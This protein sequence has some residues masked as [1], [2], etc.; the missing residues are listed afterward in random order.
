MFGYIRPMKSELLVREYE[1][2]KAVY[3]QL[4]RVLGDS[5]GIVSRFT[6]SYDAAFYAMIAIGLKGSA[7]PAC[8]KRC[9]M[10]PAK[11]CQYIASTG[12]EYEKAA[13]LSVMM[14]Y[15]KAK[16]NVAD[17]RFAKSLLSRL[18]LPYL[19]RKY[20]KAQRN[21]PGMAQIITEMAEQQKRAE[22]LSPVSLDACCEPTAQM[23]SSL[24]EELGGD[25]RAHQI[26]LKQFGYFL[27]RWVYLMDAAD[28]LKDD[29]HS[30]S[31]N[32]LVDKLSLQE[33][34]GKKASE[35][36]SGEIQKQAERFCNEALNA[37]LAMMMPALNLIEFRQFGPIIE[38]I[39]H[40][41]L[42]QVQKEI[43]FLHVKEK[44]NGRSV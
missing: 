27:G 17:E 21:D 1:E 34:C 26:A 24:M 18:T 10:N 42:P 33:F 22:T 4:C 12:Q 23:L 38:N 28:D 40:K 30:G 3:C 11:K 16:D 36:F 32:P 44:K 8:G 31:F 43:L 41:G 6:L 37:N 35:S 29:L 9:T 14:A 2:Y 7:V 39:V 25:D 20:K 19:K 15:Y 13:A 5:L